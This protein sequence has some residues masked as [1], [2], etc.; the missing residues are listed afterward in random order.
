[1]K[2][3]RKRKKQKIETSS[4]LTILAEEKEEEKHKWGTAWLYLCASRSRWMRSDGRGWPAIAVACMG[5]QAGEEQGRFTQQL[6]ERCN[7][8]VRGGWCMR[9]V[10]GSSTVVAGVRMAGLGGY[11]STY[12]TVPIRYNCTIL[13]E[14]HRRSNLKNP[15]HDLEKYSQ[16]AQVR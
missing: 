1:M 10:I 15:C 9:Y 3:E 12:S 4:D 8:V 16:M 6:V 14:A 7:C 2:K 13:V 5:R 11:R